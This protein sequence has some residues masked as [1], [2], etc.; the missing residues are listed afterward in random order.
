MNF[1]VLDH[2]GKSRMV[3]QT[4]LDDG[5]EHTDP[6]HADVLLLDI[7]DPDAPIRGDL[8]S[9]SHG[10]VVL[11]PHGALPTYHG[12]YKPEERVDVQLV[13]GS[14]AV[15]PIENLGLWRTVKAV[16]WTYSP[17]VDY[18]PPAQ[19]KH[20]LFGAHHPYGSGHLEQA[21]QHENA[22][23]FAALKKLDVRI[24]VQLFGTPGMNGLPEPLGATAVRSSLTVD[25]R[26]V[27]QADLVIADGTL[28]CLA[29]A[30]GKPVVMFGQAIPIE[31]ENDRP[32]TGTEVRLP[33]YPVDFDDGPLPDLIEAACQDVGGWWREGFVGGPFDPD[34][35]LNVLE[36]ELVAA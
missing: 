34:M 9:R 28:A 2:Q 36:K 4:L 6:E 3:T 19:V 8:I 16:G 35:L 14:S 26:W 7:D 15:W 22:R 18:E 27:D 33:R 29:M 10:L 20:I 24:T 31:D 17:W 12:F 30:R 23:V 5:W 21:F 13:H 25:W 32:H 1:C 11:Y